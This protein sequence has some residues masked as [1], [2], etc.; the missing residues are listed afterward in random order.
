M[1]K[2]TEVEVTELKEIRDRLPVY[3]I[4]S[5]KTKKKHRGNKDY[6]SQLRVPT[7]LS[8]MS[9]SNQSNGSHENS[10]SRRAYNSRNGS[11]EKTKEKKKQGILGLFKRDSSKGS[12]NDGG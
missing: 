7:S 8:V 11:E 1:M 12:K 6:P 5:S 2:F 10:E 4:D 3:T 9:G